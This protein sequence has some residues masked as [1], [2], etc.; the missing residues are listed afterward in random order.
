MLLSIAIRLITYRLLYIPNIWWGNKLLIIHTSFDYSI[1]MYL[2]GLFILLFVIKES[3]YKVILNLL[4]ISMWLTKY[5]CI[6]MICI[7]IMISLISWCY[8]NNQIYIE[9]CQHW[10]FGTIGTREGH[11][12]LHAWRLSHCNNYQQF[13]YNPSIQHCWK[14]CDY[15]TGRVNDPQ[16]RDEASR[17]CKRYTSEAMWTRTGE[18]ESI[19]DLRVHS[20]MFPTVPANIYRACLAGI[21]RQKYWSNNQY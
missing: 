8:I 4:K 20:E 10:A 19:E 7:L 12:T 18:L 11:A 3:Q 14:G 17:M 5:N 21:R 13:S 2:I 15:G 1:F 6:A 16:G 9:I